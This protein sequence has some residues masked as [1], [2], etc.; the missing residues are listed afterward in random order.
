[1]PQQQLA[2]DVVVLQAGALLPLQVVH[3][4]ELLLV[5]HQQHYCL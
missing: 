5:L 3:G 4:A 1:L 2:W